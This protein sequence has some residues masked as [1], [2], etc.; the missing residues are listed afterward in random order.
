MNENPLNKKLIAFRPF[1][2]TPGDLEFIYRVY[3]STRADEMK[4]TDW[5]EKQVEDFLRMQFGIQHKQY[6]GNYTNASFDIILYDRVPVGRL[7][8]DRQPED[9]R[10]IDI[11]LLPEFRGKGLG[12]ALMDNLTAEAD[13]EKVTLSLHVEQNNPALGLYERLGFEKKNLVGIYFYMVRQPQPK[14]G[15]RA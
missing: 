11:A 9:I 7:Y 13:R 5:N 4:L 12:S 8:V 1:R 3:A 10:I 14:E 15:G 6:M 2:E